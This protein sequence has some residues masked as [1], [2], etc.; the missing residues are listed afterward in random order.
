MTIV[1]HHVPTNYK[2]EILRRAEVE[3][4]SVESVIDNAE[5]I[6]QS[7]DIAAIG[8]FS[9]KVIDLANTVSPLIG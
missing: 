6:A 7:I 4:P 8:E 3:L 5:A 1:R 9:T 2:T